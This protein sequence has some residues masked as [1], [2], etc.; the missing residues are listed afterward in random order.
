MSTPGEQGERALDQQSM[1]IYLTSYIFTV[2]SI[3]H[4]WHAVAALSDWARGAGAWC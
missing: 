1:I 4:A 3:V 2:W